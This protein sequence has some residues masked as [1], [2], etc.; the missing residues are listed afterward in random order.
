MK[1]NCYDKGIDDSRPQLNRAVGN[2]MTLDSNAIS[3]D[4]SELVTRKRSQTAKYGEAGN[5]D[6]D[7]D[8]GPILPKSAKPQRVEEESGR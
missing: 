8:S 4:N 6:S 7:A 2:K 5:T 3:V 1:S